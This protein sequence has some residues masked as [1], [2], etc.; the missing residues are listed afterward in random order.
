MNSTD[1]ICD[2][3][4]STGV[5]TGVLSDDEEPEDEA[6]EAESQSSGVDIVDSGDA[7]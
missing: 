3:L 1:C 2:M 5:P 7:A 4:S 6:D